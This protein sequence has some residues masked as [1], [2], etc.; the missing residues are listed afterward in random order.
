MLP[1][2]FDMFTQLQEHRDRT[3]GGLGIGLTLAKRLVELHGGHDRGEQRGARARAAAFTVRLPHVAGACEAA[4]DARHEA[5]RSAPCRVLVAD[6]N[7][8]R[9]R[10]DAAD[11]RL[12][13]TTSA[14]PRTAS[15]RSRLRGRSSRTSRFSTSA[16]RAWTATRRRAASASSRPPRH[17]RRA[18]RMGPGRGQA[19]LATRP[20]SIITSPSRPTVTC[21]SA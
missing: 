16:C 5:A 12:R 17:A 20:A 7:P 3:H 9:G 4:V 10:D 8:G 6:D 11:A 21:S 2:I 15:R 13:A 1:R 14:W 18:D 19:A